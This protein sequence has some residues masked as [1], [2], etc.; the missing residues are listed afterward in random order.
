MMRR[1]SEFAQN[2]LFIKICGVTNE[3]DALLA[4]ALGADALGFNLVPGSPRLISPTQVADIVRRVPPEVATIG[5]F[6]NELPARVI[7]LVHRCGLTGAQ[8]HGSES[9][10]QCAE[11]ARA[12][13]FT[14]QAFPAGDRL[15]DR[16]K[17][18]PVEVILIDNAKPGSGQLFDWS[19]AEVPD[20]KKMLLAGGLDPDNV[21]DAIDQVRP[22]GVDVSSG[23]EQSYGKKDP[24][25]LRQFIANARRAAARYED[26]DVSNIADGPL[27]GAGSGESAFASRVREAG[28]APY[29]WRDD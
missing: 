6:R 25:K 17:N 27:G 11:V 21:S 13:G 24:R 14:M 15:I 23:T 8:L 20:G 19:L 12:V 1:A 9:A 29:D 22:W 10:A 18:Y 2:G 28:S 26:Y 16:A 4:T 7:E 5:I 3:E